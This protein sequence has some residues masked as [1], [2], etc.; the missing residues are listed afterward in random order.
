LFLSGILVALLFPLL[1][2]V[3]GNFRNNQLLGFVSFLIFFGMFIT[4]HFKAGFSEERPRPNSLVYL[5]DEDL[6][7]STW[8][9]YDQNFD[10]YTAPFFAESGVEASQ[11]IWFGSKNRSRFSYTAV[12]PEVMISKPYITIER[13]L[14]KTEGE[15]SYRVKIAP[16]RKISR[17]D[18]FADR[19]IN[20]SEFTVNGKEAGDLQPGESSLHIFKNRWSDRLL[21]YYAAGRD[22]LRLEMSLKEGINPEISLL[23]AAYDLHDNPQLNVPM[24]TPD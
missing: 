23:E 24:R 13:T 20:F 11:M 7:L 14:S 22:T 17:I 9:T 8:N 6:G 21:T 2:P 3:F 12:A 4:A 18:L 15:A 10:E 16:N 19:A 1:W 5:F